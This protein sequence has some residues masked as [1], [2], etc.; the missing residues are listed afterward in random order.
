M[1]A[2]YLLLLCFAFASAAIAQAI[3]T[4]REATVAALDTKY[5]TAA[6]LVDPKARTTDAKPDRC[7]LSVRDEIVFRLLPSRRKVQAAFAD[8]QVGQRVI[9]SGNAS[10]SSS[11][12]TEVTILPD[13]SK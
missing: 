5:K 13:K 11:F 3:L 4:R 9:L 6:F 7:E 1:R 12:A 2:L 8:L 10:V